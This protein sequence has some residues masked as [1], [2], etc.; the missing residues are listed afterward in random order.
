MCL[1][2]LALPSEISPMVRYVN[3]R[4]CWFLKHTKSMQSGSLGAKAVASVAMRTKVANAFA[5]SKAVAA[6]ENELSVGKYDA[7]AVL[8]KMAARNVMEY[9]EE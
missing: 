3:L 1:T 5:R 2:T 8:Y 7:E 9:E 6:R 4:G